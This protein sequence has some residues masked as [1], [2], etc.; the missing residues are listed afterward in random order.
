M[1]TMANITVKK[2]DGT[3]DI[4][5]TAVQGSGG[6]KS[7][8]IWRSQSVGSAA[9]FNPEM[10]MTSRPNSDGSVR[11]V[12]GVIDYKQT[13]TDAYGV[14][15]KANVGVFQFSVAVPQ[16]MPPADLNEFCAQSCN[17]VASTLFK[18]S[19][20]VGFAPQ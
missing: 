10:R 11:R 14:T 17:L 13:V 12:E 18:D 6:D 2:N 5:W 20:K 4:T 7:P 19:L 8:A 15:R 1:P 9:A 16:G 3:T